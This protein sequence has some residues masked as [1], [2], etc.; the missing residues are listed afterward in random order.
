MLQRYQT[1]VLLSE[2]DKPFQT[3]LALIKELQQMY[4]NNGATARV[5]AAGFTYAFPTRYSSA[6]AAWAEAVAA[7]TGAT[8][9]H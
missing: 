1:Q 7:A 3:L 6:P 4:S 8:W 9:A 2:L 5:L